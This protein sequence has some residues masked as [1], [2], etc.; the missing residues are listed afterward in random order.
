MAKFKG[1]G[2]EKSIANQ[3]AKDINRKLARGIQSA[4]IEIMNGLAQAGPAWSGVFS[5]SWR[6]VPEGQSGGS[7]GPSGG[8]YTYSKKDIRITTVEKYINAGNKK[9]QFINTSDHANIAIDAEE[10]VYIQKGEPIKPNTFIGW[11]P[12]DENGEQSPHL[13]GDLDS[14]TFQ[15]GTAGT[16]T[17]PLDWYIT[18]TKGGGL[19]L[20]FGRGFSAGFRGGF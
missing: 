9:F 6:F 16:A 13:R 4:A 3:L 2:L 18:Y 15:D 5:A 1:G 19:S 17:A 10:S 14:A 11:R 7:A 12:T 8:V 20:D